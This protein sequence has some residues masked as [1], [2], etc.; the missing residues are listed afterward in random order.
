MDHRRLLHQPAA[1]NKLICGRAWFVFEAKQ[2]RKEH[3]E[4]AAEYRPSEIVWWTNA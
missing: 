3:L 1:R 4:R 2:F